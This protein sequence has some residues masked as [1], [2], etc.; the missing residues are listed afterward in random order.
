MVTLYRAG[1][2]P[3]AAELRNDNAVWF[4]GLSSDWFAHGHTGRTDAVFMSLQVETLMFWGE[5]RVANGYEGSMWEVELPDDVPLLAYKYKRYDNAHRAHDAGDA[6]KLAFCVGSY[7]L[8]GT[9]VHHWYAMW[10]RCM[11]GYDYPEEWEVIVPRSVAE[12]ATWHYVGEVT[13]DEDYFT[14][15]AWNPDYQIW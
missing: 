4:D 15:Y 3:T 2:L 1:K 5:H 7:W 12:K 6:E 9:D 11:E 10:M 14:H 13:R 8:S